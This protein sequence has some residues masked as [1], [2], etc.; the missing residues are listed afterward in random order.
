M[1]SDKVFGI[2]DSLITPIATY[3]S[4]FWLPFIISKA[5]FNSI[6]KLMDTWGTLKAETL[7]QKC[8]RMF[9]SVHSKASRLAVLGELGRYPLFINTLAQCLNYKL[10]LFK[11]QS[12]T[13]LI[14]DV[15]T[16]MKAMSGDGRDCWLTRVEKIE[17]LLKM[18]PNLKF[19]KFSGKNITAIVKGK[20][21]S[22]WLGKVNEFKSNNI[23]SLD[24]NKLRV[25]RQF[26]S[27]FSIEPYIKLVRNRNQRSSLSR[28]R[29]SAHTLATELLR[30]A[31]PVIPLEQRF[32]AYC[33]TKPPEHEA[34][35]G[36]VVGDSNSG[37]TEQHFLLSCD[38]FKNMRNCLFE[39]VSLLL[40]GFRGF[41]DEDKFKTLMCPTTPQL[42]KLVNRYINFMFQKREKLK[43][44]ATLLDL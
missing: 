20:F 5:G 23:D 8:S 2:F 1:E 15:M 35:I 28:L 19:S 3:A 14:G 22:F 17:K 37:D 40:H 24:H 26:K 43:M 10:S 9:L 41:S 33:Q 30:R 32:C 12:S 11:R 44:G 36:Q 31:R 7:N 27:S 21:D 25:Y 29:I 38:V 34:T 4:T 13:N 42:T 16:E 6:E 18:P 39:K